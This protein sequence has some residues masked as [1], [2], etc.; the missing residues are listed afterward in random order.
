MT[1]IQ[2]VAGHSAVWPKVS[3]TF[4]PQVFAVMQRASWHTF[5][6]LASSIVL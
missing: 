1:L 6:V 2:I 5:Q 4:I 3:E